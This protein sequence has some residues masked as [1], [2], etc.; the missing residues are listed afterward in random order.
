MRNVWIQTEFAFATWVADLTPLRARPRELLDVALTI[1]AAGAHHRV[2]VPVVLP[3]L[4]FERGAGSVEQRLVALWDEQRVVDAFGFTGA[5]RAPGAP[6]SST[7][8][9]E[10]AWFD[11]H[12]TVV[13]APTT[14]L[15]AVLRELE[16][17][18][19]SIG[20]GFTVAFPPVRITGRRLAFEG[21]P[22]ALAASHTRL[23]IQIRIAVH[24]D[25]WFP[26]VF[27]SAH[28]LADHQ[29]HFDNRTLASIHTPRLNGFLREIAAVVGQVGGEWRVDL[30]ETSTDARRW[31]DAGGVHLD[32]PPPVLFPPEA[33][34]TEWF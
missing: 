25:I 34:A 26:Y 27:G 32:A 11:R 29:R 15:G 28:P 8:E 6:N 30:D 17:V 13:V 12:D 33:F 10:L 19:N 7:V 14:N 22:P 9:A 24:S 3:Q 16:P 5:A 4:H 20:D 1:L 23:P 31:L 21:D 2:F 18:P